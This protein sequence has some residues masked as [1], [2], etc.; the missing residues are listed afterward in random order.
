MCIF[1]GKSNKLHFTT[2]E[3]AMESQ[4][5]RS[6]DYFEN[7]GLHMVVGLGTAATTWL[8]VAAR[9]RIKEG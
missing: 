4:D 7:G 3:T 5:L 8:V 9:A 1:V 2:S 6:L